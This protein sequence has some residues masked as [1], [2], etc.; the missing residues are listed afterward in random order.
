MTLLTPSTPAPPVAPPTTAPPPIAPLPTPRKL[1]LFGVGVTAAGPQRVVNHVM[2]WAA[3]R[4]P[5]AVAFM[6]VHSLMIAANDPAHRR[7]INGFDIVACDG[8][9]VRWA[10]NLVHRAG[11]PERVYGPDA[12]LS[13]C[14]ECAIAGIGVY[15]YGGRPETL[16]PLTANLL[17]LAPALKIVGAES[18]PF[19]PLTDEED[20]AAVRRINASGAGVVFVGIGCPKQEVFAAE[21]RDRIDAVQL[22]VGAAFDFHAGRVSQAP[23]W[24]QRYGLEWFYRLCREPRRLWKRYLVT[25]SQ[26]LLRLAR[27]LTLGR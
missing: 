13:V 21:H 10:L 22:C 23:A 2:D 25:N 24:M 16:E 19:R 7:R 17:G 27:Q 1:E 9:P 14:R 6:P 12:M 20:A 4:R 8:Q 26:F 5:A 18:P 15:L 3:E 11:L